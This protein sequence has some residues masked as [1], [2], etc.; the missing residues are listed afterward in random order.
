MESHFEE[1]LKFWFEETTPKQHYVKD[2]EFDNLIR[3]RFGH[4]HKQATTDELKDWRTTPL[5]TLSEIIILDQ[6]SRNIYR[7]MPE[8]FQSDEL[9]L[10]LCEEAIEKGFDEKLDTAQRGF[11]YMPLMHSETKEVH[12]KAVQHFSINGLELLFD[13]ELKHKAIIDR[14][15]RYPHRN[16]ILGRE[17]TPEETAFLQEPNSSF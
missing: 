4:L 9:A 7:D 15:G 6:F 8:S 10:K 16:K 3:N 17:S 1:V 11:L 13:F 2:D 5:G 14:F 12:E